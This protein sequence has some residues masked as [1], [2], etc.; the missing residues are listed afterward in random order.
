MRDDKSSH[1]GIILRTSFAYGVEEGLGST[2]ALAAKLGVSAN[3]LSMWKTRGVPSDILVKTSRETG[4]SL[5]WLETG[6]GEETTCKVELS[7][8]LQTMRLMIQ[9]V[10]EYLQAEGKQLLPA[11]KAELIITLYEMFSEE[12]GKKI[13]KKTVAKLIKLA[14]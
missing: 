10:E 8:D 4:Y 13:D 6:E 2:A 11:K 14:S 7:V 5:W 9:A 3:T 12:E 1:D